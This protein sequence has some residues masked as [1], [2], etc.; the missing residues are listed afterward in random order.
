M[1]RK[2]EVDVVS[3]PDESCEIEMDNVNFQAREKL[4]NFV[5]FPQIA[6]CIISAKDIIITLLSNLFHSMISLLNISV[7]G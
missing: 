3:R 2:K 4:Y 7:I 1:E 6:L 5:L